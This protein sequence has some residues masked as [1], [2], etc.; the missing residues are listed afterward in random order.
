MI[1][2]DK[3]FEFSQIFIFERISFCYLGITRFDFFFSSLQYW[4][5]T[6]ICLHVKYFIDYIQGLLVSN[7]K[8]NAF[9]RYKKFPFIVTLIFFLLI[10]FFSLSFGQILSVYVLILLNRLSM[11]FKCSHY[12]HLYIFEILTFIP[13]YLPVY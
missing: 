9:L 8:I 12:F 4:D 13:F 10:F 2:N 1:R 3:L 5:V 11:Y 7:F 6:I